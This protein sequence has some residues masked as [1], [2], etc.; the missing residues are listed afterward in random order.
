MPVDVV[1]GLGCYRRGSVQ[2]VIVLCG[3]N[4][5]FLTGA[6]ND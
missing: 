6:E 2:F 4:L 5:R 1:A 3:D